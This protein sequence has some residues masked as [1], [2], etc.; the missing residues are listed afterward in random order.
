MTA[1]KKKANEARARTAAP[2]NVRT[3]MI[4]TPIG[5]FTFLP[6]LKH[7]TYPRKQSH[8]APTGKRCDGRLS[9]RETPFLI[10]IW[11]AV[12]PVPVIVLKFVVLFFIRAINLVPFCQVASV[13]AVFAVIP[14][15]IVMVVRVVDSDLNTGFLWYC[16]GCG[17]AACRKGSSQ[18]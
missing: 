15:V 2:K 6:Y 5:R 4:V 3:A 7:F 1:T 16:S 13:G 10:V 18:E 12:T 9:S 17:G 11:M 8:T 14:V